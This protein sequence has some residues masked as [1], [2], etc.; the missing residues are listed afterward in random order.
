MLQIRMIIL[1]IYLACFFLISFFLLRRRVGEISKGLNLH[2]FSSSILLLSL[3]YNQSKFTKHIE[4]HKTRQAVGCQRVGGG[5]SEGVSKKETF[6]LPSSL[7]PA[8]SFYSQRL[9][10][11]P[12]IGFAQLLFCFIFFFMAGICVT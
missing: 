3:K 6:L 10:N 1:I 7:I 8:F 4:V 12:L 11:L 5:G 9:L 2:L